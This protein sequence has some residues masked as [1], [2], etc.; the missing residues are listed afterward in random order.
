MYRILQQANEVRERRNQLLHPPYTKPELL[1][2]QPN[3]VWSWDITKLRGPVKWTYYYLYVIMDIFSRYIVGWMVAGRESGEL[4][5]LLIEETCIKQDIDSDQL[6]IHSDRGSAMKSKTLSQLY[7]DLGITK[8]FNRPHVSDD[9]PFSESHF[10]TLKYRPGFPNRF[11]CQEDAKHFCQEFF[12]WYNRDHRHTGIGLLTPEVV[13]YGLS[14]EIIAQR[15]QVLLSAYLT[16]PERFVNQIPV[17]PQL[18]EA[19]W[20][21]PP[22]RSGG[23]QG[24]LP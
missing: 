19:V 4:A 21:N 11:G 16:H 2:T 17:A 10:K 1:A 18:P 23:D 12:T 13:H 22:N 24:N 9:N 6:T 20:I 8:S 7:A 15:N 5:R 14:G 3:E